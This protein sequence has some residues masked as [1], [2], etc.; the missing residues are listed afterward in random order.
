MYYYGNLSLCDGHG[1]Y[2]CQGMVFAQGDKLERTALL[3]TTV[4]NRSS[5]PEISNLKCILYMDE[6]DETWSFF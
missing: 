2:N 1:I 5:V 4:E 3:L 6:L